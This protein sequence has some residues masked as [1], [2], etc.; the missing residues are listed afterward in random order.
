ML[1]CFD[2]AAKTPASR[3]PVT[4]LQA[5]SSIGRA[6]V[7]KTAGWG[8]DSL[9]A[10]QL[11]PDN[12]DFLMNAKVETENSVLDLTKIAAAVL[13]VVGSLVA[14]YSYPEVSRL[15]RQIGVLASV[16][17]ATW[18]FLLSARGKVLASYMREAQIEIRKVVWPTWKETY[19]V[20]GIVI[21]GVVVAAVLLGVLDWALGAIVKNVIG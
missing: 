18:L 4:K 16:G 17:V 7:S 11:L 5:S 13:I 14:Y 12:A 9:L 2:A 15:V 19:Q 6:A 21:V 20:T 1:G 8:F 3:K 10:C